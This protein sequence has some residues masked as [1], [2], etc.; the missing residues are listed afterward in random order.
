[1]LSWLLSFVDSLALLGL[2]M[3][4]AYEVLGIHWVN[5]NKRPKKTGKEGR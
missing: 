3:L 2:E 4:K 1:M 5:L